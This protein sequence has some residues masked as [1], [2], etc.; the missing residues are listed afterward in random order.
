MSQIE[1]FRLTPEVG[2][3]YEYAEYTR[4]EGRYP[5]Q[6]YFTTNPLRYVGRF[7]RHITS[8]YRDGAQHADIFNLNGQEIRVDYSY[9]GRTS[10]REV[11]CRL[12]IEL[13]QELLDFTS[14]T[15]TA[16]KTLAQIAR[17]ALS[18]NDVAI[19]REYNILLPPG[20]L[21]RRTRSRSRSRSSSRTRSRSRG[22][23][24]RTF[25]K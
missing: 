11:P 7:V 12:P 10:F 2:K 15:Q 14:R 9:E 23:R 13:R 24:K 16:P 5:N 1:V 4:S 3:C 17:D 21:K 22:G 20:K 6:K 18:T 8:G 19:A 25:K